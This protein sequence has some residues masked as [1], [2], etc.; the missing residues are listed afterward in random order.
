MIIHYNIYPSNSCSCGSIVRFY[1]AYPRSVL[2]AGIADYVRKI[3]DSSLGVCDFF[4]YQYDTMQGTFRIIMNRGV[5]A[6]TTIQA[7][8][9]LKKEIKLHD[10]KEY[11]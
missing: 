8:N 11:F 3:L 5:D 10:F 2:I 1:V 9:D 7:M 4:D 6:E